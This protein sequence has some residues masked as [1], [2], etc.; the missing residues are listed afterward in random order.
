VLDSRR[1][2]KRSGSF[3]WIGGQRVRETGEPAGISG[4]HPHQL[5]HSFATKLLDSRRHGG[6]LRT[7]QEALGHADPK[8][9][10]RVREGA[11]RAA[12]SRC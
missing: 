11:P 3:A 2:Q 5:R 10:R 9:Y 8:D 12:K 7:V 4:L 1:S 6:D